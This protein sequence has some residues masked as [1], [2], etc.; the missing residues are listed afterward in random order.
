MKQ[1]KRQRVAQLFIDTAIKQIK[2]EGIET[3]SV[4]K[5]AE[6]TGYS[7]ATIYNYFT[8]FNA[9]LWACK[10]QMINELTSYMLAE[11]IA[12]SKEGIHTLF[13]RYVHYFLDHPHI[14]R[15]FYFHHVNPGEE[16]FDEFGFDALMFK[17]FGFLSGIKDE[18]MIQAIALT[19]IY[20]I[21]GILQLHFSGND[22]AN[23]ASI[24]Q[25]IDVCLDV[26]LQ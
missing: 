6:E 20:T 9:L 14:F 23:Q 25:R 21:H 5:I 22:Q 3:L 24:D 4:R 12:V 1:I 2:E 18:K 16:F 7:Y 11:D 13:K 15:F 19:C 10:K 17:S 26:L 8:D